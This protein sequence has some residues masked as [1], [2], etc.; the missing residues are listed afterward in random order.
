MN[1][2]ALWVCLCVCEREERRGV[3]GLGVTPLA[4]PGEPPDTRSVGDLGRKG[5]GGGGAREKLGV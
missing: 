4:G 5:G 1:E 2:R 3:M